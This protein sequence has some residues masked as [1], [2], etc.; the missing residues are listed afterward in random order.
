[1]ELFSLEDFAATATS[2][3]CHDA[4]QGSRETC[5]GIR[6]FLSQTKSSG[7]LPQVTIVRS[8]GHLGIKAETDRP[9]DRQTKKERER[10]RQTE[11]DRETNR[12]GQDGTGRDGTGWDRTGQT[13]RQTNT[14]IERGPNS[15]GLQPNSDGLQPNSDGLQPN[16][17]GLQP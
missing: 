2:G 12:T 16:S 11:R 6:K 10:E 8:V 13:K 3:L 5:T 15:N 17:D 7:S 9:T 14:E 1:M 4:I